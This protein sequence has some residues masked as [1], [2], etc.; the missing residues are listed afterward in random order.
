MTYLA[1]FSATG[2][3]DMF[4]I[5]SGKI[6]FYLGG[7]VLG[8]SSVKAPDLKQSSIGSVFNATEE[9][10]KIMKNANEMYADLDAPKELADIMTFITMR[11]T[12]VEET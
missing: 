12:S 8:Q 3:S 4:E 6:E 11:N 9:I 1:D 2:K 7:N 10:I 5:L